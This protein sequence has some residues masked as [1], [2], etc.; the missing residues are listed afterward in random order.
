MGSGVRIKSALEKYGIDNFEREILCEFS[1]VEEAYYM[2]SLIVTEDFIKRD[3]VYNLRQGGG[4]YPTN[5][6]EWKETSSEIRKAWWADENNKRMMIE[7]F[8]TPSRKEKVSVGIKTWIQNHPEE[9]AI[10]MNSINK[11]PKKIEKTANKHRGMKRTEETKKNV[12]ESL[13]GLLV[14]KKN[15][16]F[17]GYYITPYGAFE[18]LE[19]ASIGTGFSKI[20]IRDRC[21]E[22][23]P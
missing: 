19:A 15:G 16:N 17:K 5:P 3:D 6:E 9:H 20:C 18:S 21:C 14:G 4:G 11:N 13:K 22:T 12:S 7:K 1:T 23:K 2:E 10:K 8:N